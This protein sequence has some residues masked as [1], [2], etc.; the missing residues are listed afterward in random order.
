M[1][2]PPPVMR[3]GQCGTLVGGSAAAF[4][5]ASPALALIGPPSRTGDDPAAAAAVDMML[6]TSVQHFMN[7]GLVGMALMQQAGF[8]PQPAAD[9][10]DTLMPMLLP[11][12]KNMFAT[13]LKNERQL[14]IDEGAK[15]A[16][17]ASYY[18]FNK[19][20]NASCHEVG[21]PICSLF[22]ATNKLY[23]PLVDRGL[24][25][26]HLSAIYAHLIGDDEALGGDSKSNSHSEL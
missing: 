26:L 7:A 17:I 19:H 16:S 22:D 13:A 15:D 18:E 14:Y 1:L 11:I 21:S 10:L 5:R 20:T 3:L 23:Q 2:C 12:F 24:E 9:L 6:V 25:K 4:A 8:D